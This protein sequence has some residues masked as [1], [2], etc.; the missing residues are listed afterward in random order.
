[1]STAGSICGLCSALLL[2]LATPVH[3]GFM[4]EWSLDELA[5]ADVLAV[6]RVDAVIRGATRTRQVGNGVAVYSCT[7]D[8][9]VLRRL[10]PIPERVRV[11]YDCYGENAPGVS[12]YPI[13]PRLEHGP[14]LVFPLMKSSPEWRLPADDGVGLLMPALADAANLSNA[15]KPYL[16]DELANSF[17]FGTYAQKFA[18]GNYLMSQRLTDTHKLLLERLQAELKP[19]DRRWLDIGTAALAAMGIPRQP[20]EGSKAFGPMALMQLP[21]ATRRADIVAN[22]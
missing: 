6:S 4:K 3:G 21:A 19:G 12:G 1:M 20:L 17:L 18:A 11:R 16:I 5:R 10:G 15:G 14:V 2:A 8:L 9:T 22:M 13:F 7:A